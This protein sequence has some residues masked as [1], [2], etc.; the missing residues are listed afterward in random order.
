M[1]LVGLHAAMSFR[2]PAI[3]QLWQ[4]L[5]PRVA[6]ITNRVGRNFISM[7]IYDPPLETAPLPD[8]Q[9]VQWAA[10]EVS[11]FD[12]VPRALQTHVLS[13]GLYAVFTHH[14][15]ADS[16]DRTA[17]LIFGQWLPSSQYELAPREFFEVLG[18]HYRPDDPEAREDVWIPVQV[19]T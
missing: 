7:R 13:S 4:T 1:K 9:F 12:R 11:D 15:T 19:P 2:E 16:F 10:V 17:E 6:D 3:R 14:G 5:G 18:P 8:S